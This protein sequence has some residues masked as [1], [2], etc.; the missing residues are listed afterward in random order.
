MSVWRTFD[1]C[2][3]LRLSALCSLLSRCVVTE[4]CDDERRE[5]RADARRHQSMHIAE[6]HLRTG[7]SKSVRG[8]DHWRGHTHRAIR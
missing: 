6:L 7:P 5:E 3:L 1:R 8:E 4:W 2:C